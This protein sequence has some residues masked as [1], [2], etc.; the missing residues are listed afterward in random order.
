MSFILR[1]TARKYVNQASGNPKLM[2]NVMQE[3]VVPIPPLAIQNK[4][5]EVLDKLE[6]YT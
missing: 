6:A 3:I 4:I 2:S 1:K 5:V